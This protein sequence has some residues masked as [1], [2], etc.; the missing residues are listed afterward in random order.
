MSIRGDRERAPA[1]DQCR[2]AEQNAEERNSL[3]ESGWDH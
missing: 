2:R 1:Q 3:T